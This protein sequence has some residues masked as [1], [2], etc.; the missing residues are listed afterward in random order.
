MT[1]KKKV[2]YQGAWYIGRPHGHGQCTFHDINC[3]YT[4]MWET[5]VM[6]GDGQLVLEKGHKE[7]IMEARFKM[8]QLHGPGK[9]KYKSGKILTGEWEDGDLT[10]GK[11]VNVDG[12]TYEG[13]WVGGRPH[14][15]GVKTISGGKRYE[16]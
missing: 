4:G 16:G 9:R 10:S 13:D 2:T 14:G 12:T 1:C 15:T 3:K 6:N 8:G 11:M 7:F 5:G